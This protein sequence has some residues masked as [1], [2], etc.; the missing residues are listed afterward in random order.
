MPCLIP[1]DVPTLAAAEASSKALLV[2]RTRNSLKKFDQYSSDDSLEGWSHE[3]SFEGLP[4]GAFPSACDQADVPLDH[5]GCEVLQQDQDEDHFLYPTED[6]EE[7]EPADDDDDDDETPPRADTG[8]G[9]DSLRHLLT[10]RNEPVWCG[11]GPY[12]LPP[13]SPDEDPSRLTVVVDLDE[14]LVSNRGYEVL[15]RPFIDTF[16]ALSHICELVLWTASTPETAATALCAIDPFGLHFRTVICR[17]DRWYHG[18]PYTKDLR[19]LGRPL[20]RTVIIENT[21]DC[22]VENPQN[23]VLVSDYN[24]KNPSDDALYHVTL[25]IREMAASMLPV[26]EVLCTSP[27]VRASEVTSRRP[28]GGVQYSKCYRI[29]G[30]RL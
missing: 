6:E 26:E 9:H 27:L 1:P 13:I 4:G 12:L 2:H 15:R 11:E 24:Q 10:P 3:G 17:D 8:C 7:D 29:A 16:L 19:L 20:D 28:D 23:A 21:W 5:F 25:L 14:T 18:V 22:V 30:G